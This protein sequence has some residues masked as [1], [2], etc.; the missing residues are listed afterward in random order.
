M[1]LSS[2]T[3]TGLLQATLPTMT[4]TPW[5][6]AMKVDN[7]APT[8][9]VSRSHPR[10]APIELH[11]TSAVSLVLSVQTLVTTLAL[12]ATSPQHVSLVSESDTVSAPLC[13]FG[14]SFKDAMGLLG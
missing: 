1:L 5:P 12:E 7:M 11:S 8:S 9:T 13:S 14:S 2:S 3:A 4:I 6:R 10:M